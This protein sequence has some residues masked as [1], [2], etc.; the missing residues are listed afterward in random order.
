MTLGSFKPESVYC[1][2]ELSG[3]LASPGG[4]VLVCRAV[5][6]RW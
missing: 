3:H 5:L 6:A 4:G 1:C 2:D